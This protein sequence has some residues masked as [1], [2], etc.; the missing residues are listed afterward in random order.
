[1]CGGSDT[2]PESTTRSPAA[3]PAPAC[4]RSPPRDIRNYREREKDGTITL[5]TLNAVFLQA[6]TEGRHQDQGLFQV[7]EI[8]P[9]S[10]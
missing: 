4:V 6:V 8:L 3:G 10:S 1:M 7:I 9:A 2:A 5:W